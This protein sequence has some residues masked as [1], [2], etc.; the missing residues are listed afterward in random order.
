VYPP[1]S[2]ADSFSFVTSSSVASVDF[3]DLEQSGVTLDGNINWTIYGSVYDSTQSTDV[4]SSPLAQGTTTYGHTSTGQS[5]TISGTTYNE[6]ADNFTLNSPFSAAASTKYW[7]GL[8]LSWPA[9]SPNAMYWEGSDIV[10]NNG[11]YDPVF[12]W[13]AD[14][15]GYAFKLFA[16]PAGTPEPFTIGLG[17]VGVGLAVRRRMKAKG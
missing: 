7:L 11:V 4:P 17:M 13:K 3:W 14:S 1:D 6:Y 12:V 2:A 9:N 16:P 8:N 15:T 5:V 10:G